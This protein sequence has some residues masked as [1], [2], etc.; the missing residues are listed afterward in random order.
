MREPNF[1]ELKAQGRS[2]GHWRYVFQEYIG[3]LAPHC[4]SPLHSVPEVTGFVMYCCFEVNEVNHSWED[5]SKSVN[6]KIP[7]PSLS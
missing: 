5:I 4:F 7:F 6:Q 3:T 1:E 2:S